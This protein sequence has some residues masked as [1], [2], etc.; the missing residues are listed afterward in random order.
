MIS[1]LQ[2]MSPPPSVRQLV[3]LTVEQNNR[4]QIRK[5]RHWTGAG[6]GA[7]AGLQGG[8]GGGRRRHSLRIA[9]GV[10]ARGGLNN[11]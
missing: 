6:A 5:S 11:L 8:G 10:C 4:M 2:L 3:E 1:S 7:G 9:E